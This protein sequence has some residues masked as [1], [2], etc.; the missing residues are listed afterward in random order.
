MLEAT[1]DAD[2]QRAMERAHKERS[3]AV[4][5]LFSALRLSEW[6]SFRIS[7]WA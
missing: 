6:R 7:R 3:D 1:T 2:V 5:R 4:R